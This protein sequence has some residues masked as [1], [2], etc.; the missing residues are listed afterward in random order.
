MPPGLRIFERK[1]R[2]P[3]GAE[4]LQDPSCDVNI[5]TTIGTKLRPSQ[6]G[7][8]KGRVTAHIPPLRAEAGDIS[9]LQTLLLLREGFLKR[10]L[11][12]MSG[13]Y[14]RFVTVWILLVLIGAVACSRQSPSTTSGP[15]VL[16]GGLLIDGTGR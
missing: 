9:P 6:T 4:Q 15:L 2:L 13:A 7:A 16:R 8:E 11:A 3:R 12:T 5:P 14:L 1:S 10:R